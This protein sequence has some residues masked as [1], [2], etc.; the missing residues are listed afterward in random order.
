MNRNLGIAVLLLGAL[1][2]SGCVV[3]ALG[4]GAAGGYAISRDEIEGF[5]ER[6]LD[7]TWRAAYEL[8]NRDGAVESADKERAKIEAIINE[9]KVNF[10][11][12]QVSPRSV[13]FVIQA[14]R[15]MNLFPDI[16]LAQ[17][18]HQKMM[19]ELS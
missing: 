6:S 2:F 16:K 9:S 5:S 7:Q 11:A 4:A 19:K 17:S 13:R 15:N 8:F 12:E 10:S 18:L 1:L 3:L 14:R